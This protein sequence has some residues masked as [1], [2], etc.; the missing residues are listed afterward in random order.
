MKEQEARWRRRKGFGLEEKVWGQ[1]VPPE[2]KTGLCLCVLGLHLL[3][4]LVDV[5][6]HQGTHMGVVG[7]PSPSLTHR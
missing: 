2:K 4:L 5:Q 6:L 1:N 3:V 7:L